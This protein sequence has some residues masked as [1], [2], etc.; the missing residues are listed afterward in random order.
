[1]ELYSVL[2]QYCIQEVLWWYVETI[3]VHRT[4]E[5]FWGK[6]GEL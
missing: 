5:M 3:C 1:M 2:L 4:Q 6:I